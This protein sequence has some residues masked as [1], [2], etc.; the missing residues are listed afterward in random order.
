M[1]NLLNMTLITLAMA[2]T[3]LTLFAGGGGPGG[4]NYTN[5]RILL[6]KSYGLGFLKD[7]KCLSYFT[8]EQCQKMLE[9][10]SGSPITWHDSLASGPL[11]IVRDNQEITVTARTHSDSKSPIE[12][13]IRRTSSITLPEA[14]VLVLHEAGHSVGLSENL[15]TDER[16]I[17]MLFD[18]HKDYNLE[19]NI[20]TSFKKVENRTLSDGEITVEITRPIDNKVLRDI[21]QTCSSGV[22][23][24]TLRQLLEDDL[25][26]SYFRPKT[27]TSRVGFVSSRHEILWENDKEYYKWNVKMSNHSL[28]DSP[29]K[30][31][32]EIISSSKTGTL[33]LKSVEN[34]PYLTYKTTDKDELYIDPVSG[35][36]VAAGNNI[37]III[38]VPKSYGRVMP[39]KDS[40]GNYSLAT[41]DYVSLVECLKEK[42]RKQSSSRH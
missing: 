38:N 31:S 37:D 16:V 1:K 5:D 11:T 23:E 14:F 42:I 26:S 29:S 10:L 33:E 19:D 25:S 17:Q 30:L 7:Q 24:N 4:G 39:L 40:D 2:F 28:L 6:A 8:E 36:L 35:K 41:I 27:W 32:L 20:R 22:V 12:I 15:I 3:P 21:Y 9:K 13:D 18:I 34:F